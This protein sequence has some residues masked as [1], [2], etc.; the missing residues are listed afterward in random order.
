M[1][2]EVSICSNAL[3]IL[4]AKSINSFD[5]DNDRARLA[6]NLYPQLRDR[7]LRAHPWNCCVKRVILSPDAAVPVNDYA[8]QFTL[9]SD[10]LRTL[11]VGDY[12]VEDDYVIEGR[13]ILADNSILKLRYV[14]LNTNPGTW[15]SQLVDVMITAMCARMAY[16]ITQ[17]TSQEELRSTE[18]REVFK[19]AKAIDGQEQPPETF[20]DERLLASRFGGA[21]TFLV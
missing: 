17:S 13:K 4:G 9:P 6:S 14:F 3:L 11:S 1:A 18:F 10:W 8:Y 5:E 12:G 15:D 7:L 16:A 21:S 20:G 2:T 19:S